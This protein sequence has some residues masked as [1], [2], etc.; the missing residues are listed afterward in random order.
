MRFARKLRWLALLAIPAVAGC[1]NVWKGEPAFEVDILMPASAGTPQP[2]QALIP[3]TCAGLFDDAP[4][5]T[6]AAAPRNA[7]I[8]A[9]MN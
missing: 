1:A 4:S 8:Y 5:D 2:A 9:V 6:I 3:K 7:C